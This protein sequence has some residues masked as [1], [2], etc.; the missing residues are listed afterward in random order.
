MFNLKDNHYLKN[1]QPNLYFF[2]LPPVTILVIFFV[3]PL[4][5]VVLY[6]FLSK[7]SYGGITWEF[8]LDNYRQL[9]KEIYWLILGRSL[10]FAVGTTLIC[11]L[12]GYPIA[13]FIATR[14]QP[15]RNVCLF[16]VIIPF[17]TNFLV[18]TYAW[19]VLLRTEGV[20]NTLLQ[21]LHLI[22]AP[23]QLLF[24]PL[25][26][27]IGLVYGYLPLMILPLYAT[28]EKFNFTLVEAAQD[29]GAND[30]FTFT[31][32]ILPLTKKGII[33]G[34]ILV[35]VPAISAFIIP[36][37]LGGARTLMIGNII[38]NQFLKVRDWGFGSVLSIIMMAIVLIPILVYLSQSDSEKV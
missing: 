38:Q 21:S 31:K 29:L 35:F 4:L 19:I 36:D 27:I 15:W 6:S 22:Q 17:W 2:L 14:N 10:L 7:G 25:A 34:I 3:I 1:F 28:I 8:T 37:L 5:I 13:F 23:I 9:S 18:R 24:T 32:I 16:L 12:I 33:S 30:W 26:V 20:I 11:L